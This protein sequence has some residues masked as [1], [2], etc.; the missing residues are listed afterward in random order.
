[1]LMMQMADHVVKRLRWLGYIGGLAVLT[2]ASS[3]N[4]GWSLVWSDEFSQPNG[5]PPD[6]AKWVYDLGGGGWGNNELQTYTSR[7]NNCRIE[8]GCLVIEAAKEAFTGTDGISRDYTSARLKTKGRA[9]W[10]YGRIEARLK[11][12]RGQGMWP[13]FWTLGTSIDSVGWPRCGEIDIMENIGAKPSVLHGTIHGPGYSGGGG[14]SGTFTLPDGA[15][16]ADGFHVFAVEWKTNSIEWH[17]DG[18]PY[19]SVTPA[20]LP[21]GKEWVFT[22]PQFVLLNLAVGGNWPGKPDASTTFP[23]RLIVDYVRVFALSNAPAQ[24]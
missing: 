10:T 11:V 19:S 8:N 13:A 3:V 23:Q 24:R 14:I 17:V 7:T 22:Q 21:G 12:P 4:A 20:K 15:A 2:I 16:F 1:M 18:Q 6:P 9:A 5:S